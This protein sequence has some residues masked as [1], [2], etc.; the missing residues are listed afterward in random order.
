MPE[1]SEAVL[2]ISIP[3]FGQDSQ[4]LIDYKSPM[5]VAGQICNYSECHKSATKFCKLYGASRANFQLFRMPLK[6]ETKTQKLDWRC[7]PAS[8]QKDMPE[9]SEAVLG[10][11]IPYF[12]Q[13]SQEL[14]DYKSPMVVEQGEF[15][16]L[17]RVP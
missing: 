6:S 16:T 3:Y 12:G 8:H 7:F 10:I 9:M 11:S 13:E 15:A 5:V 4:V 17:F 2:G 1:M 14:I